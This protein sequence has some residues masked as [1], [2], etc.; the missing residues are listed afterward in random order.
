MF[1]QYAIIEVDIFPKVLISFPPNTSSVFML[2][3]KVPFD[4]EPN[5]YSLDME[6]SSNEIDVVKKMILNVT[7]LNLKDI[8]Y[9][10]IINYKYIIAELEN[11]ILDGSKNGIDVSDIQTMLET[12]KFDIDIAEDPI[13]VYPTL[14]YQNGG[15]EHD[16][17]CYT[18]LKGLL[19]AG[20]ISGGVHGKNRL[21]GNSLLEINVFGRRAG[22]TAAKEYK[23]KDSKPGNLSLD[24]VKKVIKTLD[25]LNLKEKRYSPMILPEYRSEAVR[26]RLVKLYEETSC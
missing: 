20:E 24:H 3:I 2:S 14:H 23:K 21:M 8:V 16:A 12:I 6:F 10:T 18:S 26:D 1:F 22:I 25:G 7:D 15:V 9:Q 17:D 19:A 4:T 11:Q 13:L 5:L